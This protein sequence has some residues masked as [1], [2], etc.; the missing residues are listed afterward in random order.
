ML[1]ANPK[2]RRCL[3]YKNLQPP[4]YQTDWQH[5]CAILPAYLPDGANG[6]EII[7]LDGTVEQIPHRLCR[8]LDDLLFHL[9]SS[10]E[11]LTRQSRT[12]LGKTARRVPLVLK[13]AFTLVPVKGREKIGEYDAVTGYIVL[14][15]AAMLI[16]DNTGVYIGFTGGTRVRVYDNPRVLEDK[17]R[18][19]KALNDE[20]KKKPDYTNMTQPPGGIHNTNQ[21]ACIQN[22]LLV[23]K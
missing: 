19:T 20:I 14:G 4:R 18:F 1:Y 7:Y 8:V 12:V 15:H 16:Q 17:I 21:R 6:T 9:Q 11:V 5:I 22:D 13:P 3:I 10:T 23:N 2:R